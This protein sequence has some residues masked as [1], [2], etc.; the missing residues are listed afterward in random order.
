MGMRVRLRADFDLSG[1]P[2]RVK[3]IR[4]AL[5]KHGMI[6][7][8]DGG[9]WFIT[10]SPHARWNDDELHSLTR[11]QQGPLRPF[12]QF[13]LGRNRTLP[14]TLDLPTIPASMRVL[15]RCLL[16]RRKIIHRLESK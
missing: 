11:H 15:L 7:A 10:G 13:L 6:L 8:D 2:N 5:K 9:N 12:L 3:P 14:D 16:W 4:I 1:F